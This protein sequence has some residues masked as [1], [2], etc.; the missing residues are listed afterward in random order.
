MRCSVYLSIFLLIHFIVPAQTIEQLN[1]QL[2]Q[3]DNKEDKVAILIKLAQESR[4]I[5]NNALK[6]YA[7]ELIALSSGEENNLAYAWGQYYLGDYFYLEDENTASI[8]Y[9]E[10]ALNQFESL[11][12][13]TGL[14]EA[15]NSLGNVYFYLDQYKTALQYANRALDAFRKTGNLLKQAKLLTLKCDILTYLE[16]YDEAINHCISSMN[17]RD[18]LNINLGKDITL[19]TIGQIYLE[20]GTV[21]KA[22]DYFFQALEYAIE[23]NEPYNVATSYSN[24]GNALVKLGNTDSAL[25]Y[26]NEALKTDSLSNDL[27]GLAYSHYDLGALLTNI[28]RYNEAKGHLTQANK[29]AYETEMPELI[30]I[31]GIQ[32]GELYKKTKQYPLAILAIKGSLDVAEEINASNTL[33]DAYQNL[34]EIFEKTGQSDSAMFYM[35]KN[36][37]AAERKYKEENTKAIAEITTQYGLEQKEKEIKILQKEK[38][39]ISLESD[40]RYFILSIAGMAVLFLLILIIILANRNSLKNK[41]NRKLQF[42]NEEILEQKEEIE[43]QKVE[44]ELRGSRLSEKNEQILESIKY[45]QQIQ[46]SLLPRKQLVKAIFPNSFVYYR[47]K[48]IVSGDFY[49]Q[50]QVDDKVAIAV[51]DCTGHG[52]PGAFMTILAN[53]LLNQ[54]ILE[55]EIHSPDL[56]ISL[57]DQKIQ[58]TLHQRSLGNSNTDGLDIGL[59]FIDKTRHEIQ[60]TG[61]KIPLYHIQEGELIIHQPDRKSVGSSHL[62]EK[63]FTKKQIKYKAGDAIYM[64]TD[65]YQDQFGGN[66][67]KKF[68]KKNFHQLITQISSLPV[69]EQEIS[70]ER[71]LYEWRGKNTQTDDILVMGIKF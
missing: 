12:S 17:I 55:S 57:L 68:M 10:K 25:F 38:E 6:L 43:A 1:E 52:V 24:I 20:L 30:A 31:T 48:D 45:A 15:A 62:G 14:G 4:S 51:I 50:A 39:I 13:F 42:Q 71:N 64:S 44:I 11:G 32:L 3:S 34:A 40:R 29:L 65:G 61:A 41:A 8:P 46:E 58:Q 53:S 23:N 27:V 67:D 5:N 47:P 22:K 33:I 7:E 54:I 28:N 36:L 70:L 18:K 35:K 63:V 21:A 56:V 69:E 49:W 19:N 26:F 16:K 9:F 60:F 66:H 2:L 59:A 37:E